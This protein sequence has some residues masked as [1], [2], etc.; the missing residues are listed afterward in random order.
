MA[1]N[2]RIAV[3]ADLHWGHHRRGDEAT[4]L[5]AQFLRR[6]L[7]DILVLAGDIGTGEHFPLCLSLFAD[8]ACRKALVPGNH[9]LW[10]EQH[11][12]RGDSMEV[13]KHHL[14]AVAEQHG[15]HY[16]DHGPLVQSEADLALVGTI[17]WY[18]YSWSVERLR[19]E[20]P[21]WEDR[22]RTKRFSRGRH[23]DARFV[24]WPLDD[25]RFTAAVVAA[26][27]R[28]L[29]GALTQVSH[30]IVVT[31]HPAWYGLSFPRLL[32]PQHLDE[33][34]WDAFAGN[35]ALEAVLGRNAERIPFVFSGH[36]HRACPNE[37]RGMR[38]FNIGGDYHF[39]RLLLCDWP[40][41]TIE[42]HVFGD[43]HLSG[44]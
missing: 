39:K 31:H 18:D 43:P 41:G 44:P 37:L 24:R 28:Q 6:H 11:D 27:E 35:T 19:R 30:A 12:P 5:L 9:D 22:L 3:T 29:Q 17:N 38:G 21:D 40:A 26:L 8:M 33:L 10:V 20:V 36:T 1:A 7:P 13:Y 25:V 16:L 4:R 42:T 14:P 32:P 2:L 23:N 34:L 15:F